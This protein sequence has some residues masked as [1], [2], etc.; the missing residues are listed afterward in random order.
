[1]VTLPPEQLVV[2]AR[3]FL[4]RGEP[5]PASVSVPLLF[6]FEELLGETKRLR[7]RVVQLEQERF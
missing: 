7:E 2:H 1:M 4:G 5:L 3:I 6:A